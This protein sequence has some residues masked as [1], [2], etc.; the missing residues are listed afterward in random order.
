MGPP[1]DVGNTVWVA[2]ISIGRHFVRVTHSVAGLQDMLVMRG[3]L[4]RLLCTQ[5][6]ISFRS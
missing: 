6:A 2:G 5:D 1:Q 4:S 3:V